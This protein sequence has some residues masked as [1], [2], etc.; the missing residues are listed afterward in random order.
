MEESMRILLVYAT[1]EGQTRKIA[2]HVA[3]RL[4]GGGNDVTQIDATDVHKAPDASA[5]DVAIV[6]APVHIG[7][8]PAPLRRFVEKNSATLMAR[9]GA[10][11]SVSL[12]AASADESEIAELDQIVEKF[13]QETGWWPVSI[14]N[15]AGALKYTEYDFFRRWMLKRIARKEG[16]PTDTNRDHEFTDWVALDKFV[17]EFVAQA[18][19]LA[20]KI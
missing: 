14:H 20:G 15:A 9:P 16:G 7:T 19:H 13:S 8:F 10:F 2:D 1:V 3:E 17:D 5:F 6:A 18:P 4:S 11:V 12:T